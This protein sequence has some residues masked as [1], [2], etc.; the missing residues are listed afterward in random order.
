MKWLQ[1]AVLA[2]LVT[3]CG[4]NAPVSFSIRTGAPRTSQAGVLSQR[5]EVVNG[6]TLTRARLLV[7]KLELETA[8]AAASTAQR[9]D[10]DDFEVEGREE[11]EVGPLVIDLSGTALEGGVQKVV[12]VAVPAGTYKQV[13]FKIAKASSDQRAS[14]DANLKA[15]ADKQASI[16]LEGTF[17][18]QPF[19]FVSSLEVKQEFEGTFELGSGTNNLT[20]NVDPSGWF[21]SQSGTRLDPRESSARSVIENNIT[22]SMRVLD[23]DDHDG[24]EDDH[25]DDHGGDD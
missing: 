5:L 25:G 7:R 12:D 8:E 6:I 24:R 15:M 10:D 17:D 18:G 14:S 3:G 19:E 16:I 2:V 1:A 13:E 4:G 23:D 11:L 9:T 20:L 21:T 22:H